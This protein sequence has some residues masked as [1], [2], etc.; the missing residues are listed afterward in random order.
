MVTRACWVFQ[1]YHQ[2]PCE[3]NP[4]VKQLAALGGLL[5]GRANADLRPAALGLV[6]GGSRPSVWV[7]MC[8]I[9]GA[10][11]LRSASCK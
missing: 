1:P 3:R 4:E 6:V 10:N 2:A 8:E 9:G 7:E 5:D 11:I